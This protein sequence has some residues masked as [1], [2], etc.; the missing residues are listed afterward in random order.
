MS[1]KDEKQRRFS[2]FNKDIA[3]GLRISYNV[4]GNL[5]LLFLIIGLIGICFAG[6]VGAGYFASLVKDVP[7][8]SYENMRNDIYNYEETSLIYFDENVYLGKLNADI[9]R[10]EVKLEN[11]SKHV[12]NAVVATEDE[13]FY[14]H[15]GVVPKAIM[16]ALFQE[17]TNASVQTGGSTLTQQLIKNQILTNEV[18]FDRKAKEILLALRLEKFFEKDEIIEAYL[19]VADFGRNSNGKNIAGVQAAAKGIFGVEAKD[20]SIPQAA[21]IAGLP[22]SPFGYTPFSNDGG[23]VK[24]S[25]EP[26]I[27]RMKTVL[28]RMYTG[29]FI[30]KEEYEEALTYDIHA[31]LTPKKPSSIERY[32]Y[33]TYEVEDRAI[34]IIMVKLAEKDGYTEEEI[35]KDDDLQAQ[36]RSLADKDLR[37]KGYRIHTTINKEIYDKMQEVVDE[38][39]YYGSDKPEKVKDPDT[40]ETITVQEPVEVGGV[41]IENTTGKIISFV[42]G[43]DFNRENLNHATDA[44]RP[45]GSTMKPLLVYAPSMELGKSQPGTVIADVP[46]T[47][48]WKP[49]NYGG[50]YHGLTSA[51]TALKY[52]Y[53]VPA[54]KTYMEIMNQNPVSY[55]E[56]MGFSTLTEEDYGIASLSLGAMTKGVTVEENVNAYGTFA[57]QGKFV[58]AYLIEKIEASNGDII[59]QHEKVENEVFSAQTAYLTL[60]MMRDVIRSGTAASLN[61]Y[62]SFSADWAGKT[63][64]GQDYRDAWFVATNPNVSFGTWIGYDTPKPLEQNYKGMSYSK[65]NILLWAKLMN[66]AYEVN[67][68]LVA[69]KNRFEMPGGIVRRSYCALTGKLPSALCRDAGLVTTDL[70]NAKYVPTTVDDSLTRGKYVFVKDRLYKV[71]STAPSE[72][73]QE[74]VMLKKEILDKHNISN[75]SDLKRLLPNTVKW[76]NLVVTEG[77]E[78]TDNG[79]SPSQVSG[80]SASGT[81]ISWR[82][83]GDNDILG[84]RVYAAANFSTNFKKVASVPASKS[85]SVTV[86]SNPAAYYVVAVD[87][88]GNESVPSSIVKI[89]DYAEEKPKVESPPKPEEPNEETQ[90]AE[91]TEGEPETPSPSEPATE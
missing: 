13:L 4:I 66:V 49:K 43:R 40:G 32:P 20:L 18:S 2:P 61:S 6:G 64:T 90:P 15:H 7:I 48:S 37:Q 16:R 62:L 8:R 89:G 55:L 53:N 38:Y 1:K 83:N 5:L 69:P 58:D 12:I 19:N 44:L 87:V 41:L 68:E 57:N 56:K 28:S 70:F 60:D 59:F 74:G 33:L 34:D 25:L 65:R 67:P 84:Y 23:A 71:P 51:R 36:Y 9:E 75:V 21:F 29:G 50:G 11:V 47:G 63:G 52:S 91:Q 85:L 80:V 3:K 72:F 79:A 10:E 24:N 76:G 46:M 45:N 14:E 35:K 31:N 22:Q 86:G 78:I 77:K 17:F 39:G 81:R 30:T 27:N 26:G 54:A 42:G 82:A 88:A 73:V